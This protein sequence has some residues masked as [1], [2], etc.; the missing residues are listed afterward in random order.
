MVQLHFNIHVLVFPKQK[1]LHSKAVGPFDGWEVGST[2]GEI[3]GSTVGFDVGANVGFA[4]QTIFEFVNMRSKTG[5]N[6]KVWCSKETSSMSKVLASI[7]KSSFAR[8]RDNLI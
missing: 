5:L 1:S 4:Q 2:L 6:V 7:A 8:A 3:D